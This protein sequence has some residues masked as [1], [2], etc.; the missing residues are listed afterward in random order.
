MVEILGHL[1]WLPDQANAAPAMSSITPGLTNE[2]FG[3][4]SAPLFR[5]GFF[6]SRLKTSQ[7]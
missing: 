4:Y 1:R 2:D 5:T 3:L 7:R 6:L